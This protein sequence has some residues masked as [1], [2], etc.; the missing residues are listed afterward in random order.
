MNKRFAFVLVLVLASSSLIVVKPVQSA[1][2]KPSVPEFTVQLVAYPYD[3]PTT[4]SI[5]PYT[6]ENITHPG[7]HVENKSIEITISN[8]PFATY[9]DAE[10]NHINL[11]YNVRVKGHF[12]ENWTELFTNSGEYPSLGSYPEQDYKSHCTVFS[13]PE[14]YP[15]NA[16]VDFQVEALAGYF[17]KVYLGNTPE[18]RN[19]FT[20]ESSDWSDTQTLTIPAPSP[21]PTSAPKENPQT[22]PLEIVIGTVIAIVLVF[23]GLLVYF[24]K[25]KR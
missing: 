12:E 3:V 20:G 9:T 16:Q 24:K 21:T 17:T 10:G 19:I 18:Y 25:R 14:A 8:Q 11:Y 5:D 6:G 7:Y 4:Y 2:A 23:A 15:S 13:I 22:L 1:I